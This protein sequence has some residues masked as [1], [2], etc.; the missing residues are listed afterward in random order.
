MLHDSIEDQ[1]HQISLDQIK[2]M[3]GETVYR[4]V[5]DCSDAIVTEEGGKRPPWKDRKTK[6]LAKIATKSQETLLVSCAEKLHHVR[7]RPY[8]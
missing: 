7:L 1:G 8:W 4:I 3:F 2:D 6:Y 5:R